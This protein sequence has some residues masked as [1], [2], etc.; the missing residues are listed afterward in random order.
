MSKA[1]DEMLVRAVLSKGL[2]GRDVLDLPAGDGELS[3][4][5]DAAGVRVT[6]ADLFPESCRWRPESVV[7]ADMNERLPFADAAFD[8]IVSQEGVEHLENLAGF[9]RECRR[10]LKDGGHLWITTPN[11]MDLSSRLAYFLTGQKSFH[12]G[13]VNED[14]TVWGADGDRVYHGHAFSLP[15]FQLRYLLRVQHFAD[16]SVASVTESS[17]S[18]VLRPL[19]RPIAGPLLRRSLRRRRELDRS[20]GKPH[21]SDATLAELERLSLSRAL[22]CAKSIL[23]HAVHREGS[24]RPPGAAG[25]GAS[26]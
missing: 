1:A 16:V 18:R 14:S 17:T 6:S 13:V 22:L 26:A 9:V 24:F 12:G 5:L 8:G 20:H 4:K 21:A 2:A 25:A 11:F 23:V 19:V 10:V 15:F 3:R 7:R